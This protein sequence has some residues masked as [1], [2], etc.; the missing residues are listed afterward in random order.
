MLHVPILN[1]TNSR[2]LTP[3]RRQ[4]YVCI[5]GA[6]PMSAHPTKK[7]P[8]TVSGPQELV[9]RIRERAYELY[10][11]RG[12]EDGRDLEDWLLAEEEIMEQVRTKAA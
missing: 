8:A 6:S 1:C 10:E 3:L 4:A 5:E 2:Q 11:A 12:K 7:P 9:I